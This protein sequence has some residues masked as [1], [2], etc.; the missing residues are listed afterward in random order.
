[1]GDPHFLRICLL[2][3]SFMTCL[4]RY[5]DSHPD[6]YNLNLLE[7][8]DSV[9]VR[10]RGGLRIS[11]LARDRDLLSFDVSP[12]ICFI[13]IGENDV[14]SF[15]VEVIA[16]QDKSCTKLQKWSKDIV[17]HFWYACKTAN[18][19]DEFMNRKCQD[20]SGKSQDILTFPG[21]PG[22]CKGR[23]ETGHPVVENLDTNSSE[24]G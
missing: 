10:A 19:M 4:G 22:F 18:S 5:M 2:G 20:I 14:L 23:D 12:D 6:L 24:S 17:N 1:M 7:D 15:S 9:C 16:E 8:R 11:R 3:H 21:P 13:Q